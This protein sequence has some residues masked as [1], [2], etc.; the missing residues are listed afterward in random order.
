MSQSVICPVSPWFVYLGRQGSRAAVAAAGSRAGYWVTGF[1]GRRRML[2]SSVHTEPGM[3]ER[4]LSCDSRIQAGPPRTAEGPPAAP[5]T[6][7][8]RE[9]S[10]LRGPGPFWPRVHLRALQASAG[11]SG[12]ASTAFPQHPPRTCPEVQASSGAN[13]IPASVPYPSDPLQPPCPVPASDWPS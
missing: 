13:Q 12:A 7:L 9:A 8:A 2:G 11:G 4:G 10:L 1:A 6:S 5:R 3:V